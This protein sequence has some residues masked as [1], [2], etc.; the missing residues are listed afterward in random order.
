MITLLKLQNH[1]NKNVMFISFVIIY[2]L[3]INLVWLYFIL[4]NLS[5]KL[6][7]NTH[8]NYSDKQKWTFK[9]GIKDKTEALVCLQF[10][11]T[12]LT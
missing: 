8:K 1:P 2:L 6:L 11:G 3:L 12:T 10:V 4:V 7:T 5:L 9:V